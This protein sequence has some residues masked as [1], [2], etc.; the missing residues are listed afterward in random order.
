MTTSGTGS[1]ELDSVTEI[2]GGTDYFNVSGASSIEIGALGD[3]ATNPVVPA[4]GS[5][6]LDAGQNLTDSGNISAPHIVINGTLEV[7]NSE[8]LALYGGTQSY[9]STLGKYVWSGGL[10]GSGTVQIDNNAQLTVQY[11]VDF[12]GLP[13]AKHDQLRWNQR[14]TDHRPIR[15]ISKQHFPAQAA[16]L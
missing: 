12:R 14:N 15:L 11:A 8:L 10:T 1:I 2:A 9:N 7:G 13:I 4:A 5:F 16:R 3:A 6:T